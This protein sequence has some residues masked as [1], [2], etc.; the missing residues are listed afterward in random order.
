MARVRL[1]TTGG[2]LG[3]AAVALTAAV[4]F[5]PWQVAAK[6]P[7]VCD[8]LSG[9]SFGLCNAYCNVQHCNIAP[10]QSCTEVRNN[11][12]KKTGSS[13]LPCD[14]HELCV[15]GSPLSSTCDPCA[16]TVCAAD[17]AC[18]T[19]SWNASCV[20]FADLLC[21][22]CPACGNDIADPGEACDPPGVSCSTAAGGPGTCAADCGSCVTLPPVCG[23][24]V[25]EQSEQC[26]PPNS[27]CAGGG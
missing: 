8:A 16:A 19:A 20:A 12:Q 24:G 27:A 3:V 17:P 21:G 23:N 2:I 18:C 5:T 9:A 4:T 26:D 25:V 15:A 1:S 7:G 22:A 13:A 11:F 6:G 10:S 14:C